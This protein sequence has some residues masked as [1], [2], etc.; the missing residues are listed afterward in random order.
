MIVI[1]LGLFGVFCVST[2]IGL[3]ITWDL[4][5]A[6]GVGVLGVILAVAIGFIWLLNI[7]IP[8]M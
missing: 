6:M 1:L 4:S 5:E 8:L 3:F 7:I 2:I